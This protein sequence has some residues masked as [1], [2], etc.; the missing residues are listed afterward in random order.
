VESA[1]A[2]R[3]KVVIG[4][5]LYNAGR[6]LT[7]AL[8]SLLGQS[9]RDFAMLMLDDGSTDGTF[10]AAG[11]LAEADDR[12]TIEQNPDRLGMVG[13]WRRT[14]ER[15]MELNPGAEYFAWAS[16]HDV[17]A[18]EWLETLFAELERDPELVL[19]YPITARITAEGDEVKEGRRT[20]DTAG[21]DRPGRRLPVTVREM[22][23]G[24]MVYGLYRA[25]A[26]RRA[27]VFR[28]VILP[29]RLLLCELALYGGFRHV[30]RKL[31]FR[32]MLAQ[33]TIARQ[34]R[35]FFPDRAPLYTYLP[36]WSVHI[37][38][39]SRSLVSG[40]RRPPGMSAFRAWLLAARHAQLTTTF[41]GKRQLILFY[42]RL[43]PIMKAVKFVR[44]R[45]R[46]LRFHGGRLFYSARDRYLSRSR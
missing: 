37:A 13:N 22:M 25:A 23:A 40:E 34:R 29:D 1:L 21:E 16:D 39:F 32:R 28:P 38:C 43:I 5:P 4:L 30:Q 15:A 17:W 12:V 36:W 26:L 2:T 8:E 42:R 7:G 27:G 14:F 24:D 31:F 9:H 19:A 46:W 11:R 20:L 10:E 41:E 3:P 6:H 44:R 18:P 45:W 35:T 33:P